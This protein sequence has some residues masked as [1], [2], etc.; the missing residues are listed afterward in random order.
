MP[1]WFRKVS[2]L[3]SEIMRQIASDAGV[4]WNQKTIVYRAKAIGYK[5]GDP[6][7]VTPIQDAAE[8]I[9][10]YRPIRINEPPETE[11]SQNLTE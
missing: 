5:N 11:Q 7:D 4:S 2:R 1:L 6:A 8:D 10:G 9:L 3:D